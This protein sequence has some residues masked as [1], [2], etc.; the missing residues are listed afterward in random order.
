MNRLAKFQLRLARL[1]RDEEC[2]RTLFMA[3]LLMPVMG[4][5]LA[6]LAAL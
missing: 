6:L 4:V 1:L 2:R 5:I 3:V